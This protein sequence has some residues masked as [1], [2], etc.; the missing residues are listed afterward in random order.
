MRGPR[1]LL[2][3]AAGWV[4]SFESYHQHISGLDPFHQDGASLRTRSFANLLAVGIEAARVDRL[5]VHPVARLDRQYRLVG[6]RERAG[7]LRGLEAMRLRHS[8]SGCHERDDSEC[9]S[10]K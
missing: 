4:R 2:Y 1:T 8:R 6:Q 5:G 7:V 3:Q 10:G 9:G